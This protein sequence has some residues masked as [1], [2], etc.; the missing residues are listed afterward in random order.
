MSLTTESRI[1]ISGFNDINV[2]GSTKMIFNIYE[3]ICKKVYISERLKIFILIFPNVPDDLSFCINSTN[4][5]SL[6]LIVLHVNFW[7]S[8]EVHFDNQCLF[9]VSKVNKF[10]NKKIHSNNEELIKQK[11]TK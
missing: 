11:R 1:A 6:N 7:K 2:A 10:E 8:L 9:G 3:N 5:Y 4:K